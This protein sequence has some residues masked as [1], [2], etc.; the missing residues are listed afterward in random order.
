MSNNL[1]KKK[2]EEHKVY[3]LKKSLYGL[4]QALRAWY[5]RIDN[6]F[7]KNGFKRCPYEHALYIKEDESGNFL[8]IC[9]YVDDFIFTSNNEKMGKDFKKSMMEEFEM[10]D[11]GLL[12]YFFGI[13]VK[14]TDEGIVFS[15]QKYA[16]DLLKKFKMESVVLCSTPMEANLK[17][18]KDDESEEVDA[19]IYRSLVGSLMYLTATRPD[20]MFSVSMLS[21]FPLL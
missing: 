10:I 3:R 14:Q 9:L 13:E 17:L 7:L 18:S 15:Q 20:L 19:S 1:Y 11:L 6:F 2:E 16:K 21:R 8:F 5:S 12:H 4:K